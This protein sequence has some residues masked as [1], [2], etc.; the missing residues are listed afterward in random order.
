[1]K[2]LICLCLLLST[3][4]FGWDGPVDEFMAPEAK[5]TVA[6]KLETAPAA[7]YGTIESRDIYTDMFH[8]GFDKDN[9]KVFNAFIGWKNFKQKRIETELANLPEV[10]RHTYHQNNRPFWGESTPPY[11]FLIHDV[12][13]VDLL[14]DKAT[15]TW[16]KPAP[17]NSKKSIFKM[18]YVGVDVT[19]D[20][21]GAQ[22][23][24][25]VLLL[26]K[27]YK[28]NRIFFLDGFTQPLDSIAGEALV[29]PN[30]LYEK[31][32]PDYAFENALEK[33][34][35]LAKLVADENYAAACD[36]ADFSFVSERSKILL[37]VLKNDYEFIL[38]T[39]SAGRYLDG[40]NRY[41]FDDDLDHSLDEKVRRLYQSGAYCDALAKASD[42]DSA[43]VCKIVEKIALRKPPP[44][45]RKFDEGFKFT[46]A[47]DVG[48]PFFI[49]DFPDYDPS[50]YFDIGFN[51]Y[52]N[53]WV[54][55]LE[56][57]IQKLDAK[58]DSCG[59]GD[60]GAHLVLGYKWF[61]TQHLESV[62]FMNLGFSALEVP[63]FPKS[64]S[65]AK[66]KHERYFCFGA[67]VYLDA[68]FEL[69]NSDADDDDYNPRRS[70]LGQ[71]LGVRL[72]LGFNNMNVSD[73]GHAKGISPYISLGLTW[74]V[75]HI[76]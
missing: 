42:V 46:A 63:P 47:V 23:K 69:G 60:F 75:G 28:G 45:K 57:A 33:R 11:F 40:Y 73:I 26:P 55:G 8:R 41:R 27:M 72:K 37:H 19:R 43:A 52:V 68:L 10:Y 15:K 61:R 62:G 34:K 12:I 54:F 67:G 21:L 36:L 35:K 18:A 29:Y 74:H 1:M 32:E 48:R 39:D 49:G 71:L 51:I 38:N 14:Y 56:T 22:L 50:V 24:Q 53:K 65:E 76:Y 7:F 31:L 5:K 2:K 16:V 25:R 70:H 59:T 20:S 13:H 3:L 58:C 9:P 64:D 6:E 66:Y 4:G 17:E 44:R 30:H